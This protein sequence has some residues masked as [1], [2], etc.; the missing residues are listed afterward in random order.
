MKTIIFRIFITAV[1]TLCVVHISSAEDCKNA[2]EMLSKVVSKKPDAKTEENIRT[3]IAQCPNGPSLYSRAGDYF[4]HWYNTESN[5]TFRLEYKKLAMEF[6]R[7]GAEH[8]NGSTAKQ[9]KLKAANLEGKREWSKLSFRGLTPVAP[10]SKDIGLS[11][12]INFALNS[13]ELTKAAQQHLN[14]LGEELA[15]GESIRI[16]LQGHTDM[17]GEAYYNK[18]L[19]IRRAESAKDYLV[20]T[21]NINPERIVTLGFGFE[22]LADEDDP[23][24][25]VNRRVEVLKIAQ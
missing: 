12:K 5:A 6:Y 3:A 7:Q 25:P 13:Y 17:R 11:L 16:S 23:Y 2:E 9:M 8:A 24:S 19:S 14:E 10:D 21:F 18:K 20:E 15:I 22:H 1:L 4:S